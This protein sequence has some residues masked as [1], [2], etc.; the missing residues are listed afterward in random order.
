MVLRLRM[1]QTETALLPQLAA[2]MVHLGNRQPTVR[3][4]RMAPMV[5]QGA[6]AEMRE[7]STDGWT[8]TIR[9]NTTFLPMAEPGAWGEGG[10]T[11]AWA[12][13]AVTEA[14]AA[15]VL[16]AAAS[17]GQEDK[18]G[19]PVRAAMA[20]TVEMAPMVEMAATAQQSWYL[21]PSTARGRRPPILPGRE[22]WRV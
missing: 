1:P 13:M 18:Q 14:R 2:T 10:E 9:T 17:L 4:A 16:P 7:S 19:G 20:G 15:M 3:E 11:E 8:I 5:C 21:S 12:G 22:E 6:E